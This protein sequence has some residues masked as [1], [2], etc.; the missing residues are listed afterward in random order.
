MARVGLETL[1]E[2]FAA[3]LRGC[4]V[5]ACR[6]LAIATAQ[7]ELHAFGV[8]THGLPVLRYVIRALREGGMKADARAAVVRETGAVAV[9]E[10]NGGIPVEALLD[11]R[12]HAA[13]LAL[14]HGMGL[15]SLL[16]A[17]WVGALG[18][19][20]APLAR[21]GMLAMAFAHMAGD[22][23]VAPFG[24]REPRLSTNPM[25]FAFGMGGPDPFVADFSTSAVSRGRAGQWKERG[26]RAPEPVFIGGDGEPTTD[27]AVVRN[28]GAILP[29]GGLHFGFRGTALAMLVEALTALAGGQPAHAGRGGGQSVHVMVIGAGAGAGAAAYDAAMRE[30]A[31]Y[32]VSSAP[33]S[34]H[35][36]P[37]L[38]GQRGWAA[39]ARARAEGVEVAGE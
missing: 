3:E 20:L 27:P 4:G 34:G 11:A 22:P 9:M 35:P 38:P 28:G 21:R 37:A 8:E 31:A 25:A 5:D 32:V 26:A 24:G 17:G 13:R 10:A 29:L 33:A 1:I 18:F 16:H 6:A 12:D 30:C 36:G 7:V 39:L 2:S 23:A 15:V 14:A 19:H